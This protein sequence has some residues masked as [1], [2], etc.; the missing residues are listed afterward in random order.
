[1]NQETIG[2]IAGTLTTASFVPQVLKIWKTRSA[3]DLSWGMAAVFCVG[4]SLW[5][6]YGVLIGAP[7]IIIANAITFV[8]SLAICVMKYRFDKQDIGDP[9]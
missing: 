2:L 1:M 8:L 3:R 4:V 6:V 9:R 5:L 7:S